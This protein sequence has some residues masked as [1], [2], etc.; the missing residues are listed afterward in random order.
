MRYF[1]L[2]FA[3]F[4]E[5]C[6]GMWPYKSDFDCK[7]PSGEYCKS[8]YQINN[9]AD[10]GDYEPRNEDENNEELKCKKTKPRYC[11]GKR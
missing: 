5:G 7:I 3:L 10:N 8:L 2:S 1:I 9:K 11:G 4:L 6:C